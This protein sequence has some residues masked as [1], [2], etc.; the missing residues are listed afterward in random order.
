ML[1]AAL[2]LVARYPMLSNEPM[3]SLQIVLGPEQEFR[4][5]VS[6]ADRRIISL[7][8]CLLQLFR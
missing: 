2:A 4:L 1:F 7:A 5:I 8:V 6:I 3:R